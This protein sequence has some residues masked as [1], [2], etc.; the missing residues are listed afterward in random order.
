MYTTFVHKHIGPTGY[1]GWKLISIKSVVCHL[2]L[3]LVLLNVDSPSRAQ[4]EPVLF[5]YFWCHQSWLDH[6][7]LTSPPLTPCFIQSRHLFYQR[8]ETRR[9]N[10]KTSI[11][12]GDIIHHEWGNL[13]T[14]DAGLLMALINPLL[15]SSLF[16]CQTAKPWLDVIRRKGLVF[17]SSRTGP[18]PW[19]LSDKFP[20]MSGE[21]DSNF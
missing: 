13:I 7:S 3:L 18:S 4:G 6:F 12:L 20:W 16:C 2:V 11:L 15:N 5:L 8:R 1:R 9:S 19:A 17:Y 21:S 10:V 14:P